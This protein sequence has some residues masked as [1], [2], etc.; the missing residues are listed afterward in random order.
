MIIFFDL[1][2]PIIDVSEKYY[3]VYADIL[4]RQNVRALP[5]HDYWQAKREKTPDDVILKGAG[6][7]LVDNYRRERKKTIES[8][9]YLSYDRLQDGAVAVLEDLSK[10]YELVLVTLRSHADQLKKEL[11][12]LDLNNYFAAVLTS[13]EETSPRWTIKVSLIKG[14]LAG[15]ASDN[16][17]VIG[18]TETDILAGHNLGYR[19]IGVLNGIRSRR[20][21][22][23][24]KP[25]H[26]V[27]SIIDVLAVI[28]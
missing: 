10:K 25:T 27:D 19:T 14:Y 22:S 18:D 26:L 21:L 24:A 7:P 15:K 13:S 16:G 28:K 1:D 11:Q 23:E 8:D 3:R 4:A 20:L 5:K 6:A 17:V 2:G 12:Y 9:Y